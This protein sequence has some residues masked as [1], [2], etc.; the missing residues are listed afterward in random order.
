M[1]SVVAEV[2]TRQQWTLW[3]MLEG[4]PFQGERALLTDQFARPM[5]VKDYNT[6]GRMGVTYK[7]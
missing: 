7:F 4:A 6:Y 5:A 2:A 3:F 1:V